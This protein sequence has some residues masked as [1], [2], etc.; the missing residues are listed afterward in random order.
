MPFCLCRGVSLNPKYSHGVSS[1]GSTWHDI[2]QFTITLNSHPLLQS[3]VTHQGLGQGQAE[4]VHKKNGLSVLPLLPS[5]V[6]GSSGPSWAAKGTVSDSGTQ[7]TAAAHAV[8]AGPV[9]AV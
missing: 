3:T 4:K 6:L 5:P 1:G 7:G 8:P 9:L 2:L